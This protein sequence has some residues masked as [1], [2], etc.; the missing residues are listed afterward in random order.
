MVFSIC[1]GSPGEVSFPFIFEMKGTPFLP[2]GGCMD[3]WPGA[4]LAHGGEWG[5][6]TG[7]MVHSGAGNGLLQKTG[8]ERGERRSK[9]FFPL[10]E[11]GG[12]GRRFFGEIFFYRKTRGVLKRRDGLL[13]SCWHCR[14]RTSSGMI[15]MDFTCVST[16]MLLFSF[17]LDVEFYFDLA[18]ISFFLRYL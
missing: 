15:I 17:L 8:T 4:W 11:G 12:G 3:R 18:L 7:G 2:W 16:N 9:I 10:A 13:I 5:W 6:R 14:R 1:L